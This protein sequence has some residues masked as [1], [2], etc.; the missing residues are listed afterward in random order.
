[1]NGFWF[2]SQEDLDVMCFNIWSGNEMR[3]LF[4]YSHH[5]CFLFDGPKDDYESR[6]GQRRG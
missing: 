5:P 3:L 6:G 4:E 2:R 1:M